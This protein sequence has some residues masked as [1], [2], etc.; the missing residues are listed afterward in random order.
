MT[1]STETLN[2]M[3]FDLISNFVSLFLKDRFEEI[4]D[5]RS[6][7]SDIQSEQLF[8]LLREA[9][10]TEWGKKYD[11]KTIFSY[12]DFRERLPIQR[13]KDLR[14]YLE[15]M[16]LGES[17]ILW[18]GLPKG[19]IPTFGYE[20]IPISEQALDEIFFQ[21]I[22]DCYALYL[23]Q[24]PESRLFSGYMVSVGNGKGDL[25]MYDL[26]RL[27]HENEPFISSLFD[28]PRQMA[29]EKNQKKCSDLILKEIKGQ[30]VSCFKGSPECLNTL[31]ER[32]GGNLENTNLSQLWPD[33]EIL[34][35]RTPVT[36]SKLIEAKKTL[37]P[38]LAYQ[39]TYCSPEGLF[40]IQDNLNDLS[41]L[42]M[43]DL[44]TFY[45]FYPADG[46]ENQCTPLEDIDLD[47]DYQMVITNCSGLWR[48]C[49]EGPKLRFV[50]KK[51]YRFIL[52]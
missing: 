47:T 23:H 30:K 39:A 28:M 40:G 45:E 16:K 1:E 18:P 10:N 3:A 26:F 14:P 7:A 4:E 15:R 8:N 43:L 49:S 41:Y 24:N 25:F 19:I 20:Q 42:L 35:H 2:N 27:L 44:S 11:F 34:F 32:A 13:S 29:D 46:A 33:A 37:P 12:Q 38:V 6:E 50:S 5:F 48:Y 22:N 31:L 51:P 9:E 21:G 17:N 36:T 52:I